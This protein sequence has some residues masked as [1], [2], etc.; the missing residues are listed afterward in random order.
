[1]KD[2]ELVTRDVDPTFVNAKHEEVSTLDFILLDKELSKEIVKYKKL[3]SY[4]SLVSDH[5]P[6]ICSI[7]I[8]I[9]RKNQDNNRQTQRICWSK[10]D[11]GEYENYVQELLQ[12]AN[13]AIETKED[14]TRTVLQ[15][16]SIMNEVVCK[17]APQKYVTLRRKNKMPMSYVIRK[18]MSDSKQAFANWKYAGR[19][20][21]NDNVLYINMKLA[22][23]QLRKECRKEVAIKALNERQ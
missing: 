20:I 2:H 18:A 23:T 21:A 16:N 6:I 9:T 12:D 5:Y 3:D 11:K 22:K 19:P 15:V 8:N 17:I 4:G 10:I 13:P 14:L 7:K 1:M